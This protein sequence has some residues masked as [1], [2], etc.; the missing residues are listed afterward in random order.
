VRALVNNVFRIETSVFKHGRRQGL[1]NFDYSNAHSDLIPWPVDE[2]DICRRNDSGKLIEVP[3]YSE[4]RWI[5]AF[6]SPG[7]I[8]RTKM[9]RAHSVADYYPGPAPGSSAST[10]APRKVLNKLSM[11]TRLHA[12]K[13][14][15]NQC[16]GRQLIGAVKRVDRKYLN[17]SAALPFVLIGHSKQFTTENERSLQPF[18]EYVGAHEARYKFANLSQTAVENRN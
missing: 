13:A 18:L 8:Y 12:W 9:T 15:F 3:I 2:E 10:S 5:G 11:L 1:V 14:D 7:R 6:L 16:T 4:Q 17:P